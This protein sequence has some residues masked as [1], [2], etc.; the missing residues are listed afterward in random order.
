[1]QFITPLRTRYRAYH[2]QAGY[3]YLAK[4]LAARVAL[5]RGA[6]PGPSV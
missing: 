4:A 5:G 2:R 3:L 1:M 6:E